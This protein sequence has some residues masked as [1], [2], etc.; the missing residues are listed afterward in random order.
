MIKCPK[1]GAKIE[2]EA[3]IEAELESLKQNTQAV[4]EQQV[5]SKLKIEQIKIVER[6]KQEQQEIAAKFN[7]EQTERAN[8]LEAQL[9]K[10]SRQLADSNKAQLELR[11]QQRELED[12]KTNFELV[13]QQK[14]DEERGQIKEQA[15]KQATE[16]SALKIREKDDQLSSLTNQISELKRR[17]EVGSQ[18][19]MGEVLEESLEDILRQNFPTDEFDEV[20]KGQ[21][22]ADVIQ[23]VR[24]TA[25]NFCGTILWEA[26]NTSTFNKSAW[27]PKLRKD[28]Q[29]A[30]ANVAVIVSS[31]LP[32]EINTIGRI[33]DIWISDFK[34]VLGLT[35]LLRQ[36]LTEVA[37]Q[38]L[39]S[40]GQADM[41]GLIYEYIT[42]LEFAMHIKEVVSAFAIMQGELEKEKRA[43]TLIWKKREKQI[44][45]VLINIAGMRGSIEGLA[46]KAL[47]EADILSLEE[48]ID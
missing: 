17:A 33:D 28:L 6:T 31:V 25:G 15:S 9:E 39:V 36:M 23:R 26:K 47:P 18:Q 37:R 46:Q 48:I 32:K 2:V 1:C 35:T 12:E 20:K 11:K 22:G 34:S 3:I 42:G 44:S 27:I 8:D 38:K 13:I 29:D 10:K 21:R 30:K 4:I 45:T 16:Q 24:N 5:A 7:A 19:A 43:I 14:L 41:Q 40:A